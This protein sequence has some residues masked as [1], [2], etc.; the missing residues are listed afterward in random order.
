M[1]AL[2][3]KSDGFDSV[4]KKMNPPAAVRMTTDIQEDNVRDRVRALK[5]HRS[6][7]HVSASLEEVVKSIKQGDPNLLL[8]L[9]VNAPACHLCCCCF[10]AVCFDIG[11]CSHYCTLRPAV[12]LPTT[13][14]QEEGEV[15]EDEKRSW[16]VTSSFAEEEESEDLFEEMPWRPLPAGSDAQN[17][18]GGRYRSALPGL[19]R[20]GS[21]LSLLCSQCLVAWTKLHWSETPQT[22]LRRRRPWQSTKT[23]FSL[24]CEVDSTCKSLSLLSTNSALELV[25]AIGEQGNLDT[26]IIKMDSHCPDSRRAA[27]PARA[28]SEGKENRRCEPA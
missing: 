8:A 1:N 19:A 20:Q 4:V 13:F 23:F 6:N 14:F 16:T 24:C 26:V 15:L 11:R 2:K 17:M 7:E 5:R 27:L 22:L 28:R 25:K 18:I 12:I 3:I 9:A 10:V 21:S